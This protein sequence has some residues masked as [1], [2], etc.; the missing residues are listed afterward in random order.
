MVMVMHAK[1][2]SVYLLAFVPSTAFYNTD[3]VNKGVSKHIIHFG[4]M[5]GFGRENLTS[6]NFRG[7]AISIKLFFNRKATKIEGK[8]GSGGFFNAR[9]G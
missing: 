5:A 4:Q 1:R 2:A 6:T 8:N 9:A 3:L 7:Y